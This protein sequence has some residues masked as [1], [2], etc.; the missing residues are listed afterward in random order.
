[1]GSLLLT[2][3]IHKLIIITIIELRDNIRIALVSV[4]RHNH[5]TTFTN[6]QHASKLCAVLFPDP[7]PHAGTK[8]WER[9]YAPR[10]HI[11]INIR[12]RFRNDSIIIA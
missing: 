11:P 3:T 2:L 6:M 10:W 12:F 4:D 5:L 7:N 8:I 9:D 1:M